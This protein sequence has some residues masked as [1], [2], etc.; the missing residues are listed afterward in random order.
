MELRQRQQLAEEEARQ[1]Y[2]LMAEARSREE[3]E[4]MARRLWQ[5][6]RDEEE[7]QRFQRRNVEKR[8]IADALEWERLSR[9]SERWGT[10]RLM[11]EGK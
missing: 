6:Q 1:T 11:A 4:Q 2:V 10:Y 3:R 5:E 7:W 9:S 8:E